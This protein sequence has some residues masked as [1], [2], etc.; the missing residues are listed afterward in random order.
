[1]RLS[2]LPLLPLPLLALASSDP[3]S[4]NHG[5]ERRQ[6][7][8]PPSCTNGF[9]LSS[10][11]RSCI[12]RSGKVVSANK[13]QCRT[14]CESGAYPVGDGTCA[15]CPSPFAKCESPAKATGCI[16]GWFLFGSTCVEVCP[17][18]AWGDSSPGKNRC[19]ACTDKDAASCSTGGA[20]AT[21]CLTNFLHNG[22][23]IDAAR[24]PDGYF[25]DS[26]TRKTVPCDVGVKTCIGSGPGKATSCGKT[27]K[28]D[29]LL[30]TPKATCELHCPKATYANK[31]LGACLPCDST[32]ATC[33][34]AG[35][36]SCGK[37]TAGRQLFLT[38]AKRCILPDV[39][40]AGYFP[41]ESSRTF[42][43]CD[44]GVTSCVGAGQGK[45]LSCGKRGDGTPV[46]FRS[47]SGAVQERVITQR[48]LRRRQ[49]VKQILGDCVEASACP[50]TTWADPV[51]STCVA[52]DSDE[53]SCSKNGVGSALSCKAGRYL[54]GSKDCLTA[55]ECKASGAFFPDDDTGACSTCDPGEAACTDNG[56]GFATACATNANGDQLFLSEGDCVPAAGCPSA[57]FADAASKECH[58]CDPGALSCTGVGAATSCGFDSAE[59]AL[60]LN[61]GMCDPKSSCPAGTWADPAG[62]KCE[63]CKVFDDDA[64]ICSESSVTSC[65][66]KFAYG[67]KC[68]AECP[69]HFYADEDSHACL[70]C[71]DPDALTC[72]AI[73]ALSCENLF[74]SSGH[75]VPACPAR[76][77]SEEHLCLD[78][79][80]GDALQCTANEATRCSTK[81]LSDGRCVDSDACPPRTFANTVNQECTACSDPDALT[82]D[83]TRA[84][85]CAEGVLTLEEECKDECAEG[86]FLSSEH[87]CSRCD[88][89]D[90]L[91]C[92]AT[93]ALS[94]R[95]K[96]LT[97]DGKCE[98][99]C[100]QG[101][102][103]SGEHVCSACSD[104]DALTCT[105]DAALS[106][107]T[108]LLTLDGKCEAVCPDGF[109]AS[110]EH[111]CSRCADPDAVTC[112]STA[113]LSCGT[114]LLTL[115]GTCEASCPAGS[116]ASGEHVCSACSDPDALTCTA[117]RSLSCGTKRLTLAG[118]C[119]A[120]CPAGS[121]ASGAHVCSACSD[122]DALTC[123]ATA[124][125]SCNIK[126][127]TPDGRC[128]TACPEGSFASGAHVCSR[129]TDV[130]AVT[131]TATR[132]LS[133]RTKLLTLAGK[134]DGVCS[135][136]SYPT[137][138]RVCVACQD[139]DALSCDATMATAC[140]T[141]FLTPTGT[142]ETSCPQKF[143]PSA[144][145]R[146]C[147][148][149]FD[150]DALTCN[151]SKAT[152][153]ATLFLTPAGTCEGSCPSNSYTRSADRVCVLCSS[154]WGIG[155]ATCSADKA[156]SCEA[157]YVW[158]PS[159]SYC[160]SNAA[161]L[162]YNANYFYV[163]SDGWCRS[164]TA[165]Y[166]YSTACTEAGPT[167][168]QTS[169]GHYGACYMLNGLCAYPMGKHPEYPAYRGAVC[170]NWAPGYGP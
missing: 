47:S 71:A 6:A 81:F 137:S 87:V 11:R 118:K 73:A 3:S 157:G 126:L 142:C 99:A 104:D 149:C 31:S 147:K 127:L 35:A 163:A 122:P 102:F 94:C 1:M 46:F 27:K 129:C 100:P 146:T 164:C 57:F 40:Q 105:A 43:T 168:C 152:S 34:A 61:D 14:S 59:E 108:K 36:K 155:T 90:A 93:A 170:T 123:T 18:G 23:C 33:D 5:L 162:A 45:A 131:C 165:K 101:S 49:A 148:P 26:T 82:C 63:S 21:A 41:D 92:T 120:S 20:P 116:F 135:T 114:K 111:V 121:Y 12:C 83:A 13:Q 107:R 22:A 51:T 79:T 38:S 113:A 133:C 65:V 143:Y 66:N 37:D 67:G 19:R 150:P 151:A 42:K 28:G 9:S 24:I 10:D 117:T 128:D 78:C 106:C 7:G 29:Q 110:A 91:T 124:A 69:A 53:A 64:E 158:R 15:A 96:L 2:L 68:L 154:A 109:F 48:W 97:L 72:S 60:Y 85:S 153:C 138:D 169:C 141:K 74:L 134:C 44:D 130:D 159:G 95:T 62:R 56:V 25:A 119:E 86:S 75:C 132:A 115:G 140:K 160:I 76:T 161:C 58:S 70:P 30:L 77:R 4:L 112:T 88:D 166:P 39:G 139:P 167:S 136:G 98:D 125:L 84:L 54:S 17:P 55:D 89:D 52:C 103:A 156:L 145:D 16:N 8:S 32:A 144:A 80:D 50:A